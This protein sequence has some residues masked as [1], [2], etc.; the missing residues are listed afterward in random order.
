LSGTGCWALKRRMLTKKSTKQNWKRHPSQQMHNLQPRNTRNIKKQGNM[1][2]PKAYNFSI[3]KSK[4]TE[5]A[6]M[7]DKEFKSLLMKM[8]NNIKMDSNS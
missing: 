1:I 6:K 2:P 3:T 7:H 4:D 8:I 5:M